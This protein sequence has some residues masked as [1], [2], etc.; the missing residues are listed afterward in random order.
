MTTGTTEQDALNYRFS[1]YQ[2]PTVQLD[3]TMSYYCIKGIHPYYTS[4]PIYW[5]KSYF[6]ANWAGFSE[7]PNVGGGGGGD[8]PVAAI[9]PVGRDLA[10]SSGNLHCML[11][12]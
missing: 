12:F 5:Q 8:A 2:L 4:Q 7:G 11:H 3:D 9:D 1:G 10:E 6:T